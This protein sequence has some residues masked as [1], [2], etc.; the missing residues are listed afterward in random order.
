MS[1]VVIAGNT[2]GSVSLSAPAVAGTTTITLPGTSGTMLAPASLG[3]TGQA[4]ISNGT[5]NPT[6][7][8]AGTST[9]GYNFKALVSGTT[10]TVPS[11]VKS[12]YVQVYGAVGGNSASNHGGVGGPGY[13]EKYY[14]TPGASYSYAI[15]A[16]GANTGGAGSGG[17]YNSTGGS[18][19]NYSGTS[20]G[21]GG[22]GGAASRAG[23]GGNGSAGSGATNGSGGG[24]GGNNASGTT[25]GAGASA[26]NASAI[27][28]PWSDGSAE[29][30][31]SGTSSD[32]P[33]DGI[34][35][36]NS[37]GINQQLYYNFGLN[38]YAANYL[39]GAIPGGGNSADYVVRYPQGRSGGSQVAGYQGLIIIIEVLK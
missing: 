32:N 24:T 3:T 39:S 7:G 29:Y 22:G 33:A 28:M 34:C 8:S 1:S 4:L 30:F 37:I 9:N 16:A 13:S 27:V 15:G 5:A 31:M 25:G 26:K 11:N 17:D 2:S 21:F 12:F 35:L 19:G 36:Y 14:A 38:Q 23:N 6:W 18:G 10:Y 20:G